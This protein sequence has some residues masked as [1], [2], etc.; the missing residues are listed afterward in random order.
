MAS[1]AVQFGSNDPAL[2]DIDHRPLRLLTPRLGEFRRINASQADFYAPNCQRVTVDDV[3][4]TPQL[5]G[6]RKHWQ[7]RR[8]ISKTV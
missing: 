6:Y 1:F 3:T 5:A 2:A 7:P 8:L 4:C